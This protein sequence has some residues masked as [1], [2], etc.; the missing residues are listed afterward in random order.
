ME[1]KKEVG[2]DV[3]EADEKVVIK[4]GNTCVTITIDGISIIV[5]AQ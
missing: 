1:D 3:Y 5:Q 2:S 4:I